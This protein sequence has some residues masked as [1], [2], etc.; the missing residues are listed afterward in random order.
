MSLRSSAAGW[1]RG[2][3]VTEAKFLAPSGHVSVVPLDNMAL[4]G[5]GSSYLL[6]WPTWVRTSYPL[7]CSIA[8][9]DQVALVFLNI[10]LLVQFAG[11]ACRSRI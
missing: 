8:A 5:H 3:A 9:S 11:R 2:V 6:T 10:V 1:P 4:P 7:A